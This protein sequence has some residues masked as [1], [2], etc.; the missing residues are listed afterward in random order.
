MIKYKND[1]IK[2]RSIFFT[3]FL[4]D[5]FNI[6]FFALGWGG[7]LVR[8]S[9]RDKFLANTNTNAACFQLI[10]MARMELLPLCLNYG[11]EIYS[12][13]PPLDPTGLAFSTP[14]FFFFARAIQFTLSR[15][16]SKRSGITRKLVIL[17]CSLWTTIQRRIYS[18]STK[19]E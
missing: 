10:D 7:N 15:N 14:E 6:F 12:S 19:S 9:V 16:F 11:Y 13:A 18:I 1:I 3:Y 8:K 5:L 2:I 4:F 17:S